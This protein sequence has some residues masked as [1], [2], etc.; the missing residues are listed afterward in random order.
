VC[1]YLEGPPRRRRAEAEAAVAV[2]DGLLLLRQIA[3]PAAANRAAATLG[4]RAPRTN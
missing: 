1:A 3:G 4:V 2:L